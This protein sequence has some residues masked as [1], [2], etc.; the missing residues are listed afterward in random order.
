MPDSWVRST[1]A[2]PERELPAKLNCSPNGNPINSVGVIEPYVAGPIAP[3]G[4]NTGAA[5]AKLLTP[6]VASG[7]TP[8]AIPDPPPAIN[9]LAPAL[10]RAPEAVIEPAGSAA[11]PNVPAPAPAAPPAPN[12]PV[13]PPIRAPVNGSPPVTAEVPAP[14]AAPIRI[15]SNPLIALP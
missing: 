4:G 9:A 1:S 13:A 11:P 12:P 5:P 14:S 3:D 15:G 8:E 10:V 2:K 6:A 7:L